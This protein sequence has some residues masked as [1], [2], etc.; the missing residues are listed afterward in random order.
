REVVISRRFEIDA[1]EVT[2]SAY[3]TCVQAGQCTASGTDSLCTTAP[4][5]PVTCVT[6]RQADTYCR[7]SGKRLPSEAEWEYAA[8]GADGRK[9]PWGNATPTCDRAAFGDTATGACARGERGPLP[10]GS[11]PSGASQAGALDL[12][13]NVREWV[14]DG[15]IP[16]LSGLGKGTNPVVS[17]DIAP[18][19]VVRG[20]SWISPP[21]ELRATYR[22]PLDQKTGDPH[23]GFRCVR[24][25][26]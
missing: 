11:F 19:G 16:N 10:V 15:W 12:A 25:G 6:Q 8:R 13:G 14:A 21:G 1:T 24:G 9:Y 22:A 7:F 17:H 4:S 3:R 26:G 23:T 2:V 5:L 20:G 18:S